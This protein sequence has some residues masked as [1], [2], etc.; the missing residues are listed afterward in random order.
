VLELRQLGDDR[1]D[2]AHDVPAHDEVEVGDLALLELLVQALERDAAAGADG[3]ELL[4][5]EPLRALLGEVACLALVLAV[6]KAGST[7]ADKVRDALSTL[8]TASFFGH[9]KFDKTGQNVYKPMSVIQVQS[10][11][12]VTV[13]PTDQA[14]GASFHWPAHS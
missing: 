8:D 3:R 12:A 1:L 4:A 7:K 6:E 13:W 5:A 11:H 14:A 10:G 9:I 2:R